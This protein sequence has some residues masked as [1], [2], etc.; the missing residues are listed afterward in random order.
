MK[1][2][3]VLTYVEKSVTEDAL[4]AIKETCEANDVALVKVPY[5]NSKSNGQEPRTVTYRAG[6]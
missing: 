1:Q 4:N 6:M 5:N 2:I 3:L